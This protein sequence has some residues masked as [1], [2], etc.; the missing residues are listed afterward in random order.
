MKK[1][2]AVLATA[3]LVMLTTSAWA[4][5][6]TGTINFTGSG[7]ATPNAAAIINA[8]G[9][10]FGD[11]QVAGTNSGTY[12][13]IAVG[14]PVVFT[15]FTFNP[16]SGLV[17]MESLWTL[18]SLG[19]T[20]SFDLNSINRGHQSKYF[21]NLLGE[22]VLHATGFD[23]TPGNWYYSSQDGATAFSAESSSAPVPEP[24]TFALLGAGLLG[25]AVYGKRRRNHDHSCNA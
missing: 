24:G 1:V 2:P 18:T 6:I 12:S 13:A 15:G 8:T 7:H 22:G 19:N 11:S 20:Y 23:P 17:P 3:A 16:S 14:T 25:L 4:I 9:V 21:L 5:P 10:F